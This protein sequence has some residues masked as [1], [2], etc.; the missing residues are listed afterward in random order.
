MK[1]HLRKTPTQWVETQEKSLHKGIITLSTKH[2]LWRK[3]SLSHKVPRAPVCEMGMAVGL[4][5]DEGKNVIRV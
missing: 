1:S 3:L 5:L 2:E 4:P